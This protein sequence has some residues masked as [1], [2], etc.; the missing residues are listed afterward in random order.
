MRKVAI[1]LS[2]GFLLGLVACNDKSVTYIT[3]PTNPIFGPVIQP[4]PTPTP[5]PSP[6]PTPQPEATI[7]PNP[8]PTPTIGPVPSPSPTIGPR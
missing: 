1:L 2:L 5:T 4:T 7:G 8:T 3:G 6:V